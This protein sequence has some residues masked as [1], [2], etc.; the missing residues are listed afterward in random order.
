[1]LY[2]IIILLFLLLIFIGEKSLDIVVK[3]KRFSY[4]EMRQYEINNGFADD[5]DAYEN[6]WDSEEF[7]IK[8]DGAD[9]SGEIIINP[10]N[11][12]NRV[13]IVCHGHTANRLA[14]I[15]YANMFYKRGFHAVIYDERHFGKSTGDYCTLGD[16]E[17]DDLIKIFNF[18]KEKFNNPIIFL[19][20][21]SMGAA[22]V[23]LSLKYIKP[24]GVVADCPF[25]DSERL[26]KE[27][28]KQNLHIP[29]ALIFPVV[30]LIA[31]LQYRYDIR[32]T[33]PIKAIRNTD[34]PICFMHGKAD[35]LI[36]CDHSKQLYEICNNP[37]SKLYLFDDAIHAYSVVKDKNRYEKLLN[38][39]IDSIIE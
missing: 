6:V 13:V 23:L 32:Q 34:V 24:E 39:F 12:D 27:F 8:C 20:G 5:I 29:A 38:D 28:I 14:C 3:P 21:E 4:D 33:S 25:C 19:H 17:C 15:K 30:N 11:K 18:V 7:L 22:T 2:V 9:I 36:D 31:K 26:Y 35:T 16:K 1:M 37:K 10:E